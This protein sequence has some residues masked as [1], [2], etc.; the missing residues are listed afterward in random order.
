MASEV[1]HPQIGRSVG[2]QRLTDYWC[3]RTNNPYGAR[4]WQSRGV[5]RLDNG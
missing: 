2:K 5:G 1:A 3:G 4:V